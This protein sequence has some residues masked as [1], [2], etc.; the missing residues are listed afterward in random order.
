MKSHPNARRI[1]DTGHELICRHAEIDALV[2][3]R[4]GDHLEVYRWHK[5]G[6]LTMAKP[7]PMCAREIKRR[8][9]STVTYSNWHGQM[10]T[11]RAAAL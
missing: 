4:P 2:C 6:E 7:C 5:S 10:V 9:I 8:G 3:A 1:T 11:V